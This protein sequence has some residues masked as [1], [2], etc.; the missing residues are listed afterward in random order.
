MNKLF[1]KSLV[2]VLA[3]LPMLL[4][5]TLLSAQAANNF[6][7]HPLLTRFPDSDIA[8]VDFDEDVNYR[9]VMSSLQRTRGLVSSEISERLRGDVTKIVYEVSE[10]FN[11]QDVFDFYRE[12]IQ[13]RD[14]EE[15]FSCAGR[16][17]GSSNYWAN[18]IFGNRILYGP[19]R[20][21]FYL[22]MR[23]GDSAETS[24]HIALYIITRGN[25]RLYAYLEIVEVGGAETRIDIV[26]PNTL[27]ETLQD[28]GFIAVPDIEFQ[29]DLA[30]T[31]ESNL[32]ATVSMLQADPSTRVYLVAHLNAD[33]DIEGLMQRSQQRANVLRQLLIG[34][35]VDANRIIARGVGPLA[36]NCGAVDCA[37]RVELVLQ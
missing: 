26:S 2:P 18:D 36:P 8:S 4:V 31:A 7:D 16:E 1:M 34:R 14:Y 10:E 17:C 12:Q 20:N 22:A 25:R 11:G 33:G 13:E 32:S 15:L 3:C 5:S 9:L 29:D 23:A 24:P 6:R 28:Q 21:Q 35:G 27:L 37:D 30:L 19:E